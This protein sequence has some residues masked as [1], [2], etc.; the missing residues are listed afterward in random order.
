[1]V[2]PPRSW[3]RKCSSTGSPPTTS[4]CPLRAAYYDTELKDDYSDFD[5]GSRRTLAPAGTPLPVTPE[6]KGNLIG[7]YLFP[8]GGFDAH[9]Q[10]AFAYEGSRSS[11]L[12]VADAAAL[13]D[14]P[15][16]TFVDLAFGIENDKYAVELFVANATDEDAPLGI[17]AECASSRVR[18]P[19]LRRESAS[20]D[21]R[22]PVLAGLLSRSGSRPEMSERGAARR[23]FFFA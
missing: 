3:E 16:S 4:G 14:I 9:V 7:R 18:R 21:H 19:G 1:M 20:A 23:P 12:D 5:D 8:L 6:F 22:H 10:G 11:E 13:G 17:D 15:S 2:R